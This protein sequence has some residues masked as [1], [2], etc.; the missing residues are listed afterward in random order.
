M[1]VPIR[2]NPKKYFPKDEGHL[3]LG[4]AP[5][6]I[7]LG[8]ECWRKV[9]LSSKSKTNEWSEILEEFSDCGTCLNSHPCQSVWEAIYY[10]ATKDWSTPEMTEAECTA[11]GACIDTPWYFIGN[12]L[13][14]SSSSG[15]VVEWCKYKALVCDALDDPL[16]ETPSVPCTPTSSAPSFP[17]VVNCCPSPS[18]SSSSSFPQSSSSSSSFSSS[19]SSSSSEIITKATGPRFL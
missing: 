13:S 4:A 1:A 11:W 5:N 14:S 16:C 8:S 18:S 19:S 3:T 15:S 6:V 12:N 2:P 7:R 10:C 17:S 9:A